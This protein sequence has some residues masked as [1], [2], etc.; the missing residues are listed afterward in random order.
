MPGPTTVVI[1]EGTIPPIPIIPI[2][3]AIITAHIG[4][5]DGTDRIGVEGTTVI[6]MAGV[7][8]G[9]A[10]VVDGMAVIG[11]ANCC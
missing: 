9:T 3:Q 6:G 1:M 10:G 4:M 2:T 5:A 8:I 11:T 7:G